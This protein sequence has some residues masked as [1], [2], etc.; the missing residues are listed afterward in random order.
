[1]ADDMN[2]IELIDFLNAHGIRFPR[3]ALVG[4]LRD[5]VNHALEAEANPVIP[6]PAAVAIVEDI[7]QGNI[8]GEPIDPVLPVQLEEEIGGEAI[9]EGEPAPRPLTPDV[10]PPAPAPAALP[11]VP[12]QGGAPLTPEEEEAELDRQI[13]IE[14]KRQRLAMLRAQPAIP[15]P[16]LAQPAMPVPTIPPVAVPALP[17]AMVQPTPLRFSDIEHGVSPFTSSVD[18][19]ARKWL[20]DFEGACD[21]VGADDAFRYRSMRRLMKIG[22]DADLFLRTTKA[23]TYPD[24]RAGFLENFGQEYDPRDVMKRLERTRFDPAKTHPMGYE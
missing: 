23:R 14:E 1:M 11:P 9:G 2:R 6:I 17:V 24:L 8:Q 20:E 4:Q 16:P 18:Y 21:S 22:S 19:D 10:P 13:R 7:P 12:A 3:Q 5:L 15:A